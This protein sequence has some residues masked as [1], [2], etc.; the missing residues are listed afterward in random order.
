MT[1]LVRCLCLALLLSLAAGQSIQVA[2][3]QGPGVRNGL[4]QIVQGIA[5]MQDAAQQKKS[6]FMDQAGNV[7][8]AVLDAAGMAT[9]MVR[10]RLGE[11][12]DVT[13]MAGSWLYESAADYPEIAIQSG[14]DAFVSLRATATDIIDSG[15]EILQAAKDAIPEFPEKGEMLNRNQWISKMALNQMYMD[16][17]VYRWLAG[18]SR[19]ARSLV[20]SRLFAGSSTL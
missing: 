5:G 18:C 9:G 12:F 20:S 15:G 17:C 6:Q 19:G 11:V 1:N 7:Y 2:S 4:E 13:K 3:V 8:D 14:R 10:N 16:R